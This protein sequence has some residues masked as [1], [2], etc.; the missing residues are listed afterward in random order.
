LPDFGAIVTFLEVVSTDWTLPSMAPA[1]RSGT[2]FD[3]TGWSCA[4]ALLGITT[5]SKRPDAGE[6][7][8]L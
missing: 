4:A 5:G 1:P 6:V 8:E 2:T 7:P 3:I